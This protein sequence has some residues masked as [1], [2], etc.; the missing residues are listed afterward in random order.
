MEKEIGKIEHFFTHIS[1]AVIKLT[2]ELKLGDK[3]HIKGAST[4]FTQSVDSMQVE[5]KN[6]DVA[7]PDDSIGLKVKERVREG[8]KVF[9]ITE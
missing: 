4:D 7:G 5:H 9:K 6:V 8:D 3:I 1:V 2:D